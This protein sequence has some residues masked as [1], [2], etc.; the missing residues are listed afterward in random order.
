MSKIKCANVPNDIEIFKNDMFGEIR[1]AGTSEQPLFCLADICKAVD[2]TNPSSVKSRLEPEDT[3]LIDL[4]ALNA[5]LTM[6]GNSM[7]TYALM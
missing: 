1:V 6:V 3:Q 2:L 7:A 4:H 5:S